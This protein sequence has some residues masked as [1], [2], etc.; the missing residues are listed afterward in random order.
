MRQVELGDVGYLSLLNAE[1]TYQQA[2]STWSRLWKIAT[3]IPLFAALE[4]VVESTKKG[5]PAYERRC[6]RRLAELRSDPHGNVF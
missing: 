5:R 4:W 6:P 2:T 1:Q 3:Q